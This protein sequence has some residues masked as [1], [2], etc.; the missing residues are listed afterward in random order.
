MSGEKWSLQAK[1][2]VTDADLAARMLAVGGSHAEAVRARDGAE[3]LAHLYYA[4]E[5]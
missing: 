4:C 2:N 5:R 1:G 3:T